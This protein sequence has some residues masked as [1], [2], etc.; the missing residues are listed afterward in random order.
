MSLKCVLASWEAI[1]THSAAMVTLGMLRLWLYGRTIAEHKRAIPFFRLV[2][3]TVCHTMLSIPCSSMSVRAKSKKEG[4]VY[5]LN[6]SRFD[7]SRIAVSRC[8]THIKPNTRPHN[9][10]AQ[11]QWIVQISGLWISRSMFLLWLILVTKWPDLLET[12]T[13]SLHAR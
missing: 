9:S 7:V 13:R 4:T 8:A 3:L 10:S 5:A 2:S 11:G 6:R 1:C 12:L